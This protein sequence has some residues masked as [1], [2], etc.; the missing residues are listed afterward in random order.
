MICKRLGSG[1]PCGLYGVG[2][3]GLS[4]KLGGIEKSQR[5]RD[6]SPACGSMVTVQSL[7][8]IELS[9]PGPD[10]TIN[11]SCMRTGR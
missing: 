11:H 6:L 7:R 10:E 5:S 9:R 1:G 4:E 3:P 8:I 2:L